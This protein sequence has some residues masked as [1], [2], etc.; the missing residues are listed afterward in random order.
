[1]RQFAPINLTKTRKSLYK[2]SKLSLRPALGR[3][4]K[5][6]KGSIIFTMHEKRAFSMNQ[7]STKYSLK[8]LRPRRPTPL[9]KHLQKKSCIRYFLSNPS[10]AT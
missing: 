5:T 3:K 1:M 10:K 2:Y 4:V 9:F 8:S 7:T 6:T